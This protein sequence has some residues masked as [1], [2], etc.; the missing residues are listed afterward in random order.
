MNNRCNRSAGGRVAIAARKSKCM[1]NP[2][3]V[4]PRALSFWRRRFC[5]TWA[6]AGDGRKELGR[7]KERQVTCYEGSTEV[8][9]SERGGRNRESESEDGRM[10]EWI[11]GETEV[12]RAGRGRARQGRALPL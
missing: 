10:D 12:G 8:R 7:L 5:R 4:S 9:A 6:G 11:D 2:S 1:L 3:E